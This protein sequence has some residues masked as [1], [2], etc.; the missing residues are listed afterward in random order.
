MTAHAAGS[1]R[2]LEANHK[3][4][5][6]VGRSGNQAASSD[7]PAGR[8]AALR[9]SHCRVGVC[10]AECDPFDWVARGG[11]SESRLKRVDGRGGLWTTG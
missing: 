3:R 5:V 8:S 1:L 4:D 9:P 6:V 2:S 7:T 10:G 11:R